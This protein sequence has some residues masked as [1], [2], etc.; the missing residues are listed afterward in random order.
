VCGSGRESRRGDANNSFQKSVDAGVGKTTGSSSSDPSRIPWIVK[1]RYVASA[2]PERQRIVI[3]TG[4]A[5]PRPGH[6]ATTDSER[7]A[8]PLSVLATYSL[9]LKAEEMI[10]RWAHLSRVCLCC[11]LIPSQ[12]A[13]AFPSGAGSCPEG[14]AAVGGDHLNPA[15]TI[16]TGG[17]AEGNLQLA[18][19]GRVLLSGTRINLLSGVEHSWTLSSRDQNGFRGFLLRLSGTDQVDTTVALSSA[20]TN[21]QEALDACIVAQGVGG[22][23]HTDNDVKTGVSGVLRLDEVASNLL[24]DVTVVIEN[25]NSVSTFFYSGYT[26]FLRGDVMGNVSTDAPTFAMLTTSPTPQPSTSMPTIIPTTLIPTSNPTLAPTQQPSS[27]VGTTSPTFR[28]V[29]MATTAPTSSPTFS[30]V[31]ATLAPTFFETSSSP[32]HV[33]TS[34]PSLRPSAAISDSFDEQALPH[35]YI[36]GLPLSDEEGG[37]TV[38]TPCTICQ[39]GTYLGVVQ[40]NFAALGLGLGSGLSA[41]LTLPG[42]LTNFLRYRL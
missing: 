27:T 37:C 29:S 9:P 35:P 18:I 10:N 5:S 28:P 31:V 16:T 3:Q 26:I 40:D 4:Q 22:V 13:T 14:M 12:L 7:G 6:L 23:T 25:R 11:L 32:S 17:L 21:V 39:G 30:S 33:P 2:L 38:D 36:E 20:D 19:N 42:G 34:R 15:Y 24:L 8:T 41:C 1:Y